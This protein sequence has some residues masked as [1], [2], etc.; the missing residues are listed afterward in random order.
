MAGDEQGVK[1]LRVALLHNIMSP[2]VVSLFRQLA[3]APALDLKVI[4]FSEQE[5]N[6]RWQTPQEIG[7][8]CEIPPHLAL[9]I[10]GKDLL[11]YHINP[12][13]P[14][15]LWR[16]PFDLVICVGWD[17]FTTQSAF[18]VCKLLRRPL[19]LWSGSTAYEPSWRRTLA[20]P[21]VRL[22]VRGADACVAYG[23]R[24]KEYLV[25]LGA[26]PEKIFI[27]ANTVDVDYFHR[28]SRLAS[29]ERQELK[30]QLG[31]GAAQVILYVGQLI[32]RKG[33]ATLIRAYAGLKETHPDVGLVIV[34]YGQQETALKALCAQ[35]R[36]ADVHF[37]GAADLPE[38]PRFYGLADLFVLP[39]SEEVWGLV[40]NE[41]MA[42][43][44]P[45][46]TTD[47]V[48]AG[49]DL[50]QPGVNGFVVADGDDE[51]LCQAM[52]RI[53]DEPGCLARMGRESWRIIQKHRF[54]D[55]V[56]GLTAA[57][58]YATRTES[59]NRCE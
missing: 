54:A 48:G 7:F 29:A 46:I 33:V 35:K 56:A 17:S 31:I 30:R 4:F 44:L 58:E 47:K 41:A 1:R 28:A 27:A 24:A 13:I 42:C 5:D 36:L 15:K 37:L 23:T 21:L 14:L 12:T 57:I 9:K 39:S 8:D 53:L 19:I 11:T 40:I 43:H 25:Q 49:A 38:M 32:E 59:Q 50:V 34:G 20:A 10:R 26:P 51:E 2:H 52:A 18:L 6:R 45:V 16:E 3:S 22:M 55:A